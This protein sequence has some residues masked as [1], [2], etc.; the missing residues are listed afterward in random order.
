[1]AEYSKHQILVVDDDPSVRETI[2]TLL[3]S[4]GYDVLVAEDGFG[5][6][7]QLRKLLPDVIISDLNMPRMSG[8]EFLSIVRCRFPEILTIAM[9]GACRNDEF[10]PGVIADALYPKGENVSNLFRMNSRTVA[11]YCCAPRQ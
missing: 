8:F 9:S 3:M 11:L 5:A 10:P 4:A 2:A 6:L 1:M 7:L